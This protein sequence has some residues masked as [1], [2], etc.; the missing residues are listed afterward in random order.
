MLR[1]AC[2]QTRVSVNF[3]LFLILV[4]VKRNHMFILNNKTSMETKGLVSTLLTPTLYDL[5]QRRQEVHL[6]LFGNIIVCESSIPCIMRLCLCVCIAFCLPLC[7]DHS[8]QLLVLV[9]P[10]GISR[11]E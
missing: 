4:H 9:Y 8:V 10:F 5:Y 11:I 2:I 7:L 3:V 6:A 1:I